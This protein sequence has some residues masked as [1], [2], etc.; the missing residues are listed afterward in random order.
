MFVLSNFIFAAN[1]IL[2]IILKALQI[3]IVIRAFLSWVSPDPNNSLVQFIYKITEPMLYPIRRLLPFSLK[4][5]LDISPVVAFL[6][7]IFLQ[8]FLLSTLREIAIRL[9]GG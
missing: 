6:A 8:Q 4:F 9:S 2:D 7:I 1:S 3:L 5:G